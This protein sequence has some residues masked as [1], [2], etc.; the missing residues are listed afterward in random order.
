MIFYVCVYVCVCIFLWEK[1]FLLTFQVNDFFFDFLFR[2]LFWLLILESLMDICCCCE[3]CT[4]HVVYSSL[5]ECCFFKCCFSFNSSRYMRDKL[6]SAVIYIKS[7]NHYGIEVLLDDHPFFVFYLFF[8]FPY[9]L[10]WK[11]CIIFKKMN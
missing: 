6:D 10:V 8:R 7:L 4:R 3:L 9:F 11:Y 5:R 2:F 1:M